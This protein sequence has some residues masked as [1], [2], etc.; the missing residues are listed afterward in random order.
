[1]FFF[2]QVSLVE[3]GEVELLY[4]MAIVPLLGVVWTHDVKL[5]EVDNVIGVAVA[6]LVDVARMDSNVRENSPACL[7]VQY[8]ERNCPHSPIGA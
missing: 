4:T 5:V 3:A 8:C 2:V 7:R 6:P 1:M